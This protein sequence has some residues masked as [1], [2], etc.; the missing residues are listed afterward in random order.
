MGSAY[1]V[2]RELGGGGMSRVFV[3]EEISLGRKVV[4]KV[5]PPEMGAGLNAERFR[6]EIQLAASLQHPHVVPLHAAGRTDELVWYTMPLI[7]GE[8]L[9]ARIARQGELPVAETVRIL[10]DVADALAYAHAHNVVHRD[11]KPDNVLLSGRHAVVTD[12]GVAKALSDST[13]ESSLTSVGIALGTPSY[14]A[15]EQ[16]A[17][18]PFVDHRADIYALG[19]MA[20]EMLTGKPPFG[21]SP[22]MVLAAHVTQAPEPVT[23]RRASVPPALA[24]LVMK[25]LEKKAADRWQSA[26]EVH[27][28]L[29][30]MATP[31]G[32]M[33]PTDAVPATKAT[34]VQTKSPKLVGT[35]V[36]TA[37]LLSVAG[38][39]A[40]FQPWKMTEAEFALDP[41]VVAVLPFRIAGAD[42]SLHY[43][44]QGMQDLLHAKLTGEGGPRA[45]DVQ[46][47]VAAARDEGD[48]SIDLSGEALQRVAKRLGTGLVIQGSIVGQPER[49]VMQ[50]ALLEM[51]SGRQIAQTSIEGTKDSIFAM[52]NGLAQRLLALSGGASEAQL[53]ALTTT[54]FEAMRAYLDGQAFFRRGDYVKA[55]NRLEEAVRADSTFALGLSALI[56]ASGWSGSQTDMRRVRRLAWQHRDKLHAIDRQFFEIRVGSRYP[57]FTPEDVTVRDLEALVRALPESPL[58]WYYLGDHHFHYGGL[59]ERPNSLAEASIAFDRALALDP[60]FVTPLDHRVRV[61]EL[62]GDT[63]GFRLFAKRRLALSSEGTILREIEIFSA[64]WSGDLTERRRGQRVMIDSVSARQSHNMITWSMSV[65][66]IVLV[67]DSVLIS[68]RWRTPSTEERLPLATLAIDVRSAQGRLGDLDATSE[69]IHAAAGAPPGAYD[70]VYAAWHALE[71]DLAGARRLLPRGTNAAPSF[72]HVIALTELGEFPAASAMLTQLRALSA[73]DTVVD[74]AIGDRRHT[75]AV[76]EAYLATARG[77]SDA[78]RL[79]LLADSLARGH[80]RDGELN[81]ILLARAHLKGNDPQRALVAIGRVMRTLGDDNSALYSVRRLLE[82]RLAVATGDRERARRAYEAYLR[83]RTNPDPVLI[84]QRDSARAELAGIR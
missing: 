69:A 17:A 42:A 45:A 48:E 13:G 23:S 52:V 73:R 38:A 43:L 28:A 50:A 2:E 74:D 61:A 9:R 40:V 57:D 29:E 7:E 64:Q 35:I 22:Q 70:A 12:F 3:A 21:G 16:A 62:L 53:E 78:A 81:S 11:I 24:T 31:S 51:P 20:Y 54:N 10:R 68:P 36:A 60:N 1:R 65:P 32:G 71:G 34:A 47:V 25:C 30:L 63:A 5:L 49:F 76:A 83:W 33:T 26:S 44:R 67:A 4:V 72:E 19:A 82:A 6:R 14:M 15:P 58:A 84:P 55:T 8:S 41:K 39:L 59:S 56:E 37:I 46:S 27:Q 75:L 66:W 79:R 18:D 80:G 77:S